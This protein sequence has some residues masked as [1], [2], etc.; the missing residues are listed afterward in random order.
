MSK[1]L[2]ENKELMQEW[3]W[4]ANAGLDPTKL[5]I[6]SNKKVCWKCSKCGY[7]WTT[8]VATRGIKKHSCPVCINQVCLPGR[9][10][11]ATTHPELL[12][13]WHPTENIDLKPTDI[14]AGSGKKVWW[15]CSNCGYIWRSRVIDRVMY[16]HGCP[17]CS[18]IQGRRKQIEHLLKRQ[19]S[20]AETMPDLAKE[21]HPT[22]NGDLKPTD[23]VA[24]SK[25]KVWWKCP[26]GHDYQASIDNRTHARTN[27]P[28]CNLRNSSSF[29]E[30]AVF[31]YV[32]KLY[33]CSINKYKDC[34]MG[35]MELDIYI[36][37]IKT[38]IEYDGIQWHKTGSQYKKESRKYEFCKEHNIYLIRIK[39]HKGESWEDTADEIY[40]IP[41]IDK[42]NFH[43]LELV[44][45][46]L[47]EKIGSQ[48]KLCK[49]VNIEK[50][51]NEILNYLSK[52]DNSLAD[53]Q[54]DVAA[55]WN[56]EKNGNLIP[57]MFSV[58]SNDVVWWKC[59]DCGKEWKTSIATMTAETYGC[60]ECAK[61]LKG[62][63][64]TKFHVKKKGSL[65][66]KMP[67]LAKEWHSTKNID[68]TPYDVTIASGKKVWWKC[69]KCGHEWRASVASRGVNHQGCP[70]C[71]NQICITGKNDLA[72]THPKLAKEWHPTENVDL[73]P[74]DV[75]AGSG[76]KVYWKCSKCGNV[77]R[78]RVLDRAVY[79]HGCPE[80]AKIKKGK[81][82][83]KFHVKEKGSLAEK[84]PELAKEWHPTKNGTLTPYDITFGSHS[85]V[86]WLCTKC[87][88]EWQAEVRQRVKGLGK[89][90][91]CAK[92][93]LDF[94]F[95]K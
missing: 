21:W 24:G 76:K 47:L 42:R 49:E 65:A 72:R 91:K 59:H 38:A 77:W 75:V 70:V 44:I 39:E 56:Y 40:K 62:K 50:D 53:K 10:D 55:K 68:L 83:A 2:S 1:Y 82:L 48:K 37:E 12:K 73:K 35:K 67:E 25:R 51:K 92:K 79:N 4:E 45:S 36:P 87:G 89:C 34:L 58:A 8:A 27:C 30:Q 18:K 5:T 86:W 66:E 22:K 7:R 9:N 52:I 3:D 88:H 20:L 43:A 29:P 32:K 6:G 74:T 33:P 14:V 60:P 90:P 84:M 23:V 26:L 80:C 78:T 15:K 11:L 95:E 69:L 19:G 64:I 85:K 46:H 28:E 81:T 17:K 94:N 93:Q 16:N 61:I 71:A 63:T 41:V 13:E 31:Y 57:E 54:P